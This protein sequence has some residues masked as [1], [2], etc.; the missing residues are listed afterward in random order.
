MEE[1]MGAEKA[2]MKKAA[3]EELEAELSG[4]LEGMEKKL[5]VTQGGAAAVEAVLRHL[6]QVHKNLEAALEDEDK[7]K[8][9]GPDE[10]KVA[11]R[12]MGS[13]LY[14]V[15][16]MLKSFQ[17]EAPATHHRIDGLKRAMHQIKDYAKRQQ[18]AADRFG[19]EEQEEDEYREDLADRQGPARQDNGNAP[20]P[21]PSAPE[22]E[23]DVPECGHCELP[24]DPPTGGEHCSACV[25]YKNRYDKFPPQKVLDARRARWE[26]ARA[27]SG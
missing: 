3:A 4:I 14:L 21:E 12:F 27:N 11:K 9:I 13:E 5:L 1:T 18:R 24:I 15:Q 2:L 17:D 19:R 26:E 6:G 22:P 7:T 23:S 8:R 16:R 10:F 20:E 25:S